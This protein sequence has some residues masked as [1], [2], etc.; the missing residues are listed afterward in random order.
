MTA[1]SILLAFAPKCPICFLAYFGVFGVAAASASAYRVWLPI[2]TLLW[3]ALTI[4]L[5]AVGRSG[6][7]RVGP[8]TL[9]LV[10]GAA[11]YAGRFNLENRLIMVAGLGGLIAA[12]LWRAWSRTRTPNCD[13]CETTTATCEPKWQAEQAGKFIGPQSL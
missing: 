11:V 8:V 12:T 6:R 1:S 5:L 13:R 10:A 2:I 7:G 3:L 9:A 4:G